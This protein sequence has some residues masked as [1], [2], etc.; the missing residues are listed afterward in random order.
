MVHHD[1][2][3]STDAGRAA[4]APRALADNASSYFQSRSVPRE[5]TRLQIR[6]MVAVSAVP[7]S[8][9][10]VRR[11]LVALAMMVPP[12]SFGA[13]LRVALRPGPHCPPRP[14]PCQASISPIDGD[15][16]TVA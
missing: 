13:R 1:W 9:R 4:T 11:L 2:R 3:R 8:L 7:V 6:L 10:R 15:Q 14:R 5:G 12:R 16:A